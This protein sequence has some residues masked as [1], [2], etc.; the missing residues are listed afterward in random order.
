MIYVPVPEFYES[1]LIHCGDP[2]YGSVH[3][4]LPGAGPFGVDPTWGQRDPGS[5]VLR[6]AHPVGS[7][8]HGGGSGWISEVEETVPRRRWR[9]RLCIEWL[10]SHFIK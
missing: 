9:G 4:V 8:R 2:F 7:G 10:D 3:F 5:S 1:L 6:F